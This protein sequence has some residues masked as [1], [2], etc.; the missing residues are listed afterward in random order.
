MNILFVPNV[1]KCT[2]TKKVKVYIFNF[3]CCQRSMKILQ[4]IEFYMSE[5]NT[6]K[7]KKNQNFNTLLFKNIMGKDVERHCF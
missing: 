5:F 6:F 3:F 4:C 2:K 1:L 7:K